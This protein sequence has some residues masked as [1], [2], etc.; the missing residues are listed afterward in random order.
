MLKLPYFH[1]EDVFLTG[2]GVQACRDGVEIVPSA[3]FRNSPSKIE[4]IMS[5]DVL[6][7][8]ANSRAKNRIHKVLQYDALQRRYNDLVERAGLAGDP[9]WPKF[10]VP[11]NADL[12][13]ADQDTEEN[14]RV[15]QKLREM[16]GKGIVPREN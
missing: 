11:P 2:F 10:T 16:Q 4:E 7:H 5:G 14:K 1:L 6:I 8:Y 3:A 13:K 15:R 9:A 12:E